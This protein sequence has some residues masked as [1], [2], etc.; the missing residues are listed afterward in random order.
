MIAP[1]WCVALPFDPSSLR[2]PQMFHIQIRLH[3]FLF[4]LQ[5][6]GTSDRLTIRCYY[7][8]PL[9]FFQ[10]TPLHT[11]HEKPL[12]IE[13]VTTVV[14]KLWRPVRIL[15]DRFWIKK[16]VVCGKQLRCKTK[17]CSV[18]DA[19][20]VSSGLPVQQSLMKNK[21]SGFQPGT[22]L[23]NASLIYR[24][25]DVQM[26]L[27]NQ[28]LFHKRWMNWHPFTWIQNKNKMFPASYE[29]QIC[30]FN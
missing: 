8:P 17:G 14:V 23:I 2:Q 16:S 11:L 7:S 12:L 4:P 22:R 30:W 18:W 20:L 5:Q 13:E 10:Q 9:I 27:L 19:S 29:T 24:D 26:H 21:V 6:M 25:A 1:L 15:I 28:I 3:L